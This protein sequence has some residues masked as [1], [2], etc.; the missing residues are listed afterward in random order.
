MKSHVLL[1]YNNLNKIPEIDIEVSPCR[2][3]VTEG[4]LEVLKQ[5]RIKVCHKR[6]TLFQML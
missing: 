5:H 2:H 4:L 1:L 6:R 3:G